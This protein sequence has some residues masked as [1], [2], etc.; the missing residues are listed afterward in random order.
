[1]TLPT[2][3]ITPYRWRAL[4]ALNDCGRRG[5]QYSDD[6]F[7]DLSYCLDALEL[8]HIGGFEKSGVCFHSRKRYES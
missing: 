5:S 2:V 6:I 8:I 4:N 1:M 7:E 3:E